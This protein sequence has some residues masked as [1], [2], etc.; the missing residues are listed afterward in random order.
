SGDGK[1]YLD[2]EA[3]EHVFVEGRRL[4]SLLKEKKF[5]EFSSSLADLHEFVKKKGIP[6]EILKTADIIIPHINS[7]PSLLKELF[8]L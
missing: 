7:N 1:Y 4:F 3:L 6:V 2:G 8:M 5:E